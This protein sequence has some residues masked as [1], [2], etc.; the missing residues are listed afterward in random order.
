MAKKLISVGQLIDETWD[1]YKI[2]FTEILTISS[3]LLVSAILLT[4]GLI[5]YPTVTQIT[6]GNGY[7]AG[8]RFGIMLFSL[9]YL[10]IAPVISF[11]IYN[12]VTRAVGSHVSNKKLN[13]T[14]AMKEGVKSF[15]PALVTTLMVV[16][17]LILAVVVGMAPPAIVAGIGALTGSSALIIIG[18]IAL[19]IGIFIATF[20]TIKWGVYY[21][22]AP[23]ITILDGIKGKMALAQSRQLIEGRFWEVLGRTAIPKILFMILGVVMMSVVGYLVSIFIDASGGF[24]TDLQLRISTITNTIGPILIAI[25]I[26][27]MIIIAD[28]LLL[29]SLRS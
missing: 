16:L 8:N 27:P 1:I 13:P 10:V 14:I 26:N 4:I 11:W 5:Y 22:L 9:T 7:T 3:W 17:M 2:R 18:N 6:V 23:I 28:V 20:L 25:I 19:V 21:I 12:S 15:L 24:H 29:K